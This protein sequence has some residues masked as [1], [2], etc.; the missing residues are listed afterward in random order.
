MTIDRKSLFEADVDVDV[1]VD[2]LL[3]ASSFSLFVVTSNWNMD[4]FTGTVDDVLS[5]ETVVALDVFILISSLTIAKT[6]RTIFPAANS[7]GCASVILF[8]IDLISSTNSCGVFH[9]DMDV[10]LMRNLH[11]AMATL[12][13]PVTCLLLSCEM[14]LSRRASSLCA[15]VVDACAGAVVDA[16][17]ELDA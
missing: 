6:L 13:D 14:K 11:V 17:V 2:E 10:T 1:D 12:K 4:V 15:A 7:R 9:L 5:E 8:P 3:R 16:E